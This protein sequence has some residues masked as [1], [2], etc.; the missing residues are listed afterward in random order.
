MDG[1]NTK[2]VVAVVIAI[3]VISCA[4]A[5]YYLMQDERGPEEPNH[6]AI[7]MPDK[8]MVV[9]EVG[10]DGTM[11]GTVDLF[12]PSDD[13]ITVTATVSYAD[14]LGGQDR[15]RVELA[16]SAKDVTIESLEVNAMLDGGFPDR[17]MTLW[18]GYDT[19]TPIA[20]DD[21]GS[22]L[23][24]D[25]RIAE[26]YSLT[27]STPGMGTS[28]DIDASDGWF[29]IGVDDGY[30]ALKIYVTAVYEYFDGNTM[31]VT[32]ELDIW[33]PGVYQASA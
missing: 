13:D 8:L 5:T 16:A 18:D 11:T 10:M 29:I 15:Y 3:V 27:V 21:S 12:C 1:K 19:T 17:P 24:Y 28:V 2:I 23:D 14:Y 7:D 32:G 33:L 20:I 6:Q 26:G 30:Y 25:I 22:D 9:P 31:A 4:T